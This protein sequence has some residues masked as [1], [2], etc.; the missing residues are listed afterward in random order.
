MRRQPDR[1]IASAKRLQ[2][3]EDLTPIELFRTRL[4]IHNIRSTKWIAP[5]WRTDKMPEGLPV[6]MMP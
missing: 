5:W 1:K 6:V 2:G 3:C 4:D